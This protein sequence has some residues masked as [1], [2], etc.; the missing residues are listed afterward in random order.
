MHLR[1]NI[2]DM[3]LSDSTLLPEDQELE[4]KRLENK[5]D[6]DEGTAQEAEARAERFRADADAANAKALEARQIFEA[7][8]KLAEISAH[9]AK[10][11]RL[12]NCHII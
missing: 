6:E 11:K 10:Q 5:R 7:L 3:V 12:P 2:R 8:A 4:I 9:Y 1:F